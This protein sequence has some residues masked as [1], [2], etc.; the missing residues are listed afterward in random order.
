M[1]TNRIHDLIAAGLM[2]TVGLVL[3]LVAQVGVTAAATDVSAASSSGAL[4][5]R[6]VIRCEGTQRPLVRTRGRCTITG[7]ITD[8]GKFVDGGLPRLYPHGRSLFGAKGTLRMS[9]HREQGHWRIITG[10]KAYAGLRG[11][12][13]QSSSGPCPPVLWSCRVVFTMTGTVS[14]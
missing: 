10:T 3:V 4:R 5:G 8:R 14:R 6:V 11:R 13:W 2:A 9:L 12:G 7:A 1:S